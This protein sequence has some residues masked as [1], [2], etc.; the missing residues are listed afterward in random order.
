MGIRE[1]VG[2]AAGEIYP[3]ILMPQRDYWSGLVFGPAP[4]IEHAPWSANCLIKHRK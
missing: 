1:N 3:D 4:Q 2:G